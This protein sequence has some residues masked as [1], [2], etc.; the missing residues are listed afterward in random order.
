MNTDL[1]RVVRHCLAMTTARGHHGQMA[2]GLDG[3]GAAGEFTVDELERRTS[4][5]GAQASLPGDWRVR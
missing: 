3:F 2:I 5:A 1:V 4:T